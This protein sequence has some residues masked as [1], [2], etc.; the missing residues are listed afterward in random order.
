M[1]SH[2]PSPQLPR[3]TVIV[4]GGI[5]GAA[6]LLFSARHPARLRIAERSK[7][8][9][10]EA[11]CEVAPGASGK[12]GG[13]LAADWHGEATASLAKLSFDLHRQLATEGGGAARW[14]YRNVEVLVAG[15]WTLLSFG[16]DP[17]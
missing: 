3:H 13:F 5:V 11:S 14:G 12:A 10:L 4:G 17:V 2:V 8:T 9:L 15:S 6:T 7:L 16:S 1:A